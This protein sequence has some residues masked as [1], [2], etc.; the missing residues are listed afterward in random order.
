MKKFFLVGYW[1]TLFPFLA[2]VLST[3]IHLML[4][5]ILVSFKVTSGYSSYCKL[6]LRLSATACNRYVIFF[7]LRLEYNSRILSITSLHVLGNRGGEV[8]SGWGNLRAHGALGPRNCA[9][10]VSSRHSDWGCSESCEEVWIRFE[11]A[12]A[13][14]DVQLSQNKHNAGA[15]EGSRDPL[16]SCA[17]IRQT[18]AKMLHIF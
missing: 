13:T 4:T 5:S 14:L 7:Y 8:G 9:F 10:R 2:Q 11:G 3:F 1:S 6:L 16:S 18:S 17:M 12:G 15:V